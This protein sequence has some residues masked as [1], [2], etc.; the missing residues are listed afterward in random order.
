MRTEVRVNVSRTVAEELIRWLNIDVSHSVKDDTI[1]ISKQENHPNAFTIKYWDPRTEEVIINVYDL[2]FF[3][4]CFKAVK[5]RNR[6][7]WEQATKSLELAHI[8]HNWAR[9]KEKLD[10]DI[11]EF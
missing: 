4:E 10:T 9:I 7:N 11:I 2:D 6:V 3:T 8:D 5:S 1:T